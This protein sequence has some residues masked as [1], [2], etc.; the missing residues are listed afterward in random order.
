[1]LDGHLISLAEKINNMDDNNRNLEETNTVTQLEGE[2]RLNAFIKYVKMKLIHWTMKLVERRT[3]I[4]KLSL[5]LDGF[6]R[7]K[8]TW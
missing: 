2:M 6:I 5:P 8:L 4:I 1:M 3:Q 7:K